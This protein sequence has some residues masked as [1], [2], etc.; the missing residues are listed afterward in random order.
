MAE[1]ENDRRA[2]SWRSRSSDYELEHYQPYG[3]P[4]PGF[5]APVA[6]LGRNGN[7]T[8]EWERERRTTKWVDDPNN[9]RYMK[10][11]ESKIGTDFTCPAASL[12]NV[13]A[14]TP[15]DYKIFFS[16]PRTR[17]DYLQWAPFLLAAED[18]HAGKTQKNR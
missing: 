14:Y 6:K 17:A 15:G 5:I 11:D 1:I 7:C 12:F 2:R 8:F 4:G 18:H 13:S 9:P 16:D 3:N 10:A